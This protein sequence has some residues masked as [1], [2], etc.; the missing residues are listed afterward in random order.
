MQIDIE[1]V[2]GVTVVS[3]KGEL[4]WA[5]MPE[6][7]ERILTAVRADGRMILDL[8][9][10]TYMGS[11]GLRLVLSVFRHVTDQG[12][13]IL[14][15]GLSLNLEELMSNTGFLDFFSYRDTLAAG[16]AAMT[17]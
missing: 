1:P 6:A 8:S 3:M 13:R 10:V 11:G 5:A 14:L 2:Q 7:E 16:I 4:T 17:S 12:G 9:G 15:V